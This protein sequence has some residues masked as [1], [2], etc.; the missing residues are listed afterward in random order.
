MPPPP[1][2]RELSAAER[3]AELA[4]DAEDNENNPLAQIFRIVNG[5]PRP[6]DGR[7][8]RCQ[9]AQAPDAELALALKSVLKGELI[10]REVFLTLYRRGYVV[11]ET[12]GHWRLAPIGKAFLRAHQR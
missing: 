6:G 2:R 9:P 4:A 8:P 10:A 7:P 5:C 1:K 3:A 12:A 11:K